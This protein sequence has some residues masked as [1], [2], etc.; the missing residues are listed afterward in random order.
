MDPFAVGVLSSVAA[1]AI[2]AASTVGWRLLRGRKGY[3]AGWWWQITYPPPVTIGQQDAT[4]KSQPSIESASSELLMLGA[5][6]P[7]DLVDSIGRPWSIEI[8]H[9][10]HGRSRFTGSMW[11][12]YSMRDDASGRRDTLNRR[13]QSNGRAYE[14]AIVDGLYWC[15]RGEGGHGVFRLW[16]INKVS[17]YCGDFVADKVS[18]NAKGVNR[19]GFTAPVEW[20]RIGSGAE[21]KM[22]PWFV[23]D[24]LIVDLLRRG[25]K[26]WPR[27]VRRRM[28]RLLDGR[29]P[30]WQEAAAYTSTLTGDLTAA[31][32]V[33]QLKQS[34][35]TAR[36]EDGSNS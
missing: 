26:W 6:S 35:E 3:L 20:I 5:L 21:I 18:P 11:R 8:L 4:S 31:H 27:S 32:A 1:S 33:A 23:D 15:D 7:W 22:L 30:A 16:T 19:E 17:H 14:D 13:W 34:D 12:V 28:K 9:L 10:R 24:R 36:I 25:N 2:W 29:V